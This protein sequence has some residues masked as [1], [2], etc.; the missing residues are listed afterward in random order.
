MTDAAYNKFPSPSDIS[1][2]HLYVH[3]LIKKDL[4]A[5][6]DK[7]AHDLTPSTT[8]HVSNWTQISLAKL[9]SNN[10]TVLHVSHELLRAP[11][12]TQEKDTLSVLLASLYSQVRS[13][14]EADMQYIEARGLMLGL[15]LI[16]LFVSCT[17]GVTFHFDLWRGPRRAHGTKIA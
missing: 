7:R 12:K 11:W 13:P 6:T 4:H 8:V 9:Q 15:A 5:S 1:F 16:G 2:K 10:V 14:Y 3:Y 17:L